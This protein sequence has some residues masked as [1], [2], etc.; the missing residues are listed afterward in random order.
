MVVLIV[1]VLVAVTIGP[2]MIVS[3]ICLRWFN[4]VVIVV[5]IVVIA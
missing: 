2:V 3:L 1:V 5:V 4:V